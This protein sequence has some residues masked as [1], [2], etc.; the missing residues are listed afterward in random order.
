[1]PTTYISSASGRRISTNQYAVTEQSR[2]AIAGMTPGIFF[3]Y[4][5]EPVSITVTDSRTPFLQVFIRLT[6]IIGGVA[7]CMSFGY[8]GM[9]ALFTR[10]RSRSLGM[11]N[12]DP[13][14]G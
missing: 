3:K 1:M 6:N 13:D 5:L 14:E 9:D 8:K 2:E 11:L 12:G 7:V 4:D 10:R